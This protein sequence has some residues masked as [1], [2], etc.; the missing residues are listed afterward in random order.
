MTL[1]IDA[2]VSVPS[3][4]LDVRFSVEPGITVLFGPTAAGKTVTLRLVAGLQRVAAGFVRFDGVTFDDGQEAARPDARGIGYAPQHGALW[5]HKTV[6]EHVAAFTTPTRAREVLA[7]VSLDRLADRRPHHLS[8]GERQR[9]SLARAIARSA[10]LLLLDEP[11]S[12]LHDDARTNMGTLVRELA[13]NDTTILFVTHDRAEARRV[14]D[15]VI[16]FGDGQARQADAGV[17]AAP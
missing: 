12:A 13:R 2:R 15:S 9:V 5:P 8:G 7:R 14:A 16:V 4:D 6:Y 1:D 11:F 3:F 10:K 17:L